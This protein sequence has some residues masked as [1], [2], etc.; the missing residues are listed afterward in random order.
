MS[1]GY[2]SSK[3]AVYVFALPGLLLFTVFTVLPILPEILV[4]FQNHDGFMSSGWVGLDNYFQVL[5]S[6]PFWIANANTF[7]VVLLSLFVAL[8]ISLF[9]AILL[10]KHTDKMKTFFKFSTVFPAVLSVTVICQ[11]WVAMLEPQWGLINSILK[12]LGFDSLATDWLTNKK[13][14]MPSVSFA[15]LWQ[16]VGL[17][18]LLFYAGIKAIPK[19]FFEAAQLEGLGFWRANYHITIPLLK[20]IIKYVV[21]ISTMGSMA[22]FAHTRVMTNGGPGNASRTVMYQMYYVSFSTSEFGVGCAIAIFFIIECLLLTVLI[23]KTFSDEVI[24]Y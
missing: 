18:M 7:M 17:N 5:Q 10:T 9:F 1:S 15:F 4:S 19:H 20:D 24:E 8:P 21:I 2:K 12:G 16:Y 6:D 13:T 23:N 14:V 11:M 3:G 22:M